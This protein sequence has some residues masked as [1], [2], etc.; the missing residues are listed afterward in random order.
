L[1]AFFSFGAPQ[2]GDDYPIHSF[3][4]LQPFYVLHPLHK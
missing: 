3:A 1:S 2:T 4:L